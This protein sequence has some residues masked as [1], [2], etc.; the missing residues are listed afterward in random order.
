MV[1]LRCVD[2]CINSATTVNI[3][4]RRILHIYYTIYLLQYIL[5]KYS[6][7]DITVI[8]LILVIVWWPSVLEKCD[9]FWTFYSAFIVIPFG[10]RFVN[11]DRYLCC[12][13]IYEE[14]VEMC[15]MKNASG[16][17]L[18]RKPHHH[19]SNLE[20]FKFLWPRIIRFWRYVKVRV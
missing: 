9:H 4:H 7:M 14:Y 1:I 5:I 20:K 18:V 16:I 13:I 17:S 3:V 11:F 19:L 6:R 12:L 15:S 8:F 10:T 2:R